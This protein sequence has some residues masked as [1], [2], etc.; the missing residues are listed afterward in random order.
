MPPADPAPAQQL[1]VFQWLMS[2]HMTMAGNKNNKRLGEFSFGDASDSGSA[3]P[4]SYYVMEA[5]SSD[6]SAE[7]QQ[8]TCSEGK[9]NWEP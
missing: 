8:R 1:M 6:G 2:Q 4:A 7:L 3:A 5:D 9:S